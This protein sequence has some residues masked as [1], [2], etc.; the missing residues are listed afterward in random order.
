MQEIARIEY[1]LCF[2]P[3]LFEMIFA[4]MT[5]TTTT[6]MMTIAETAIIIGR[7]SPSLLGVGL[8]FDP[9]PGVIKS[10]NNLFIF[11]PFLLFLK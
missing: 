4:I 3:F 6:A 9:P 8:I 1:Q 10:A 2:F 5:E 11:S 7:A